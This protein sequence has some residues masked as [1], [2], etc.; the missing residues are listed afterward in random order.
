MKISNKKATFN[1]EIIES[2]EAGII[3]T[4]SEV[5]SIKE[6][7]ANLTDSF[8]RIINGDLYLV[9]AE[10]P[11]YKYST[12]K[13]YD[14]RRSRKLLVKR[15]ELVQIAS[16]LKSKNLLLIP[17]SIYTKGKLVKVEVAYARG[18][19]RYEKKQREKERDLD[20]ELLYENRKFVV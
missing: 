8:V 19:K 4:G 15:H 7:R 14:A 13:F 6:G 3:L 11:Q 2:F 9:N 5:K 1:Y 18:R 17:L 12:D 10:V 20:R 16:K